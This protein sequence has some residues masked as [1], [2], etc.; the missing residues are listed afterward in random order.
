MSRLNLL[1]NKKIPPQCGGIFLEDYYTGNRPA[2]ARTLFSTAS[3][4]RSP[5]VTML[6]LC[7]SWKAARWAFISKYD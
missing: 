1:Q 6:T 7:F 5:R 2:A 3:R 4:A